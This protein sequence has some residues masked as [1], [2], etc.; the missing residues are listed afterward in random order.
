MNRHAFLRA[1]A[2]AALLWSATAFAPAALA[3]VNINIGIG[4]P[5][6]API[7]E[8]VPA[9]RPGYVWAPGYWMWDDHY[10]KHAWKRGHWETARPGYVYEQPRWVR[11]SNGWVMQPERWNRGPDYDRYY[12]PDRGHRG[13]HD[14]DDDYRGG[15]PPG[16][17]CPPGHA[18]K[19][20][21]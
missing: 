5:P 1:A 7:Y 8:A 15:P 18:K 9:P 4:T 10:R 11:A 17:H 16:Y 20:E 3:Q 12:G 13:R 21:C 19:G 6:P 14:H 2:G